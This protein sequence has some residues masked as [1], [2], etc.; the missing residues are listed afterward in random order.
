VTTYDIVRPLQRE[1]SV[2]WRR[3]GRCLLHLSPFAG[4]G[5]LASYGKTLG[6]AAMADIFISY[7]HN[8]N[9]FQQSGSGGWIDWIHRALDE[10]PMQ[11][12]ATRYERTSSASLV[13]R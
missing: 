11:A 2:A 8:D 6:E 9:A 1:S 3:D 4:E 5:A 12:W 13:S 7:A 10:R